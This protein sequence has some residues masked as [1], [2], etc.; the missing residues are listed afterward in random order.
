MHTHTHEFT[1]CWMLNRFARLSPTPHWNLA[2]NFVL[3]H[4]S[5]QEPNSI[6]GLRRISG[7]IHNLWNKDHSKAH[8]LLN[9]QIRGFNFI[10][11]WR[12]WINISF[13]FTFFSSFLKWYAVIGR[14]QL[15]PLVCFAI[16]LAHFFKTA[17]KTDCKAGNR[18]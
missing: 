9:T 2:S 1:C 12:F 14:L 13:S 16:F 7:I 17:L 15:H 5:G 6:A 18:L 11:K 10:V 3:N 4:L 8:T